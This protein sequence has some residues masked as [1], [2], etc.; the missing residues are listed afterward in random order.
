MSRRAVAAAGLLLCAT[1]LV[2]G[3]STTAHSVSADYRF[4]AG[5]TKGLAVYSTRLEDHCG[6]GITTTMLSVEGIAAQRR[7]RDQFIVSN[8]FIKRD[9]EDP[10]GYFFVQELAAGDYRVS[11]LEVYSSRGGGTAQLD[12]HFTLAPGAVHYLGEFY[13]TRPD[14]SRYRFEVNDEWARDQALLFERVG[15]LRG[16]AVVSHVERLREVG[17]PHAQ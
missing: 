16:A 17:V 7:V 8:A 12:R 3:C 5:G 2:T 11:Q 6:A 15:S 10:P 4:Q 1:G 9:F 13:V 14:C